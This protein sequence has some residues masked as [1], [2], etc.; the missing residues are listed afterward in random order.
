MAKTILICSNVYPPNFVGGAEL[1]AHYQAKVLKAKGR[2]V[3]VFAGENGTDGERYSM[4]QD[5]YDGLPVFRIF[6]QLRDYAAEFVNFSHPKVDSHF[7]CLLDAFSPDVVHMHNL[8][9][10]SLG[11]IHAAKRRGIKTVMT[12][13]DH[14]GVCFKNTLLKRERE[15]CTDYTRCAE[16][17]PTIEDGMRRN[18]PIQMRRDYMKLQLADVDAFIAPSAYLGETYVRAG[19]PVEKMNQIW[20]GIDVERFSRVVK[21]KSPERV[22]FTFIGFFGSHKGIDVLVDALALLERPERVLVN[23]VGGGGLVDQIRNRLETLRLTRSAK[24]WGMIDSS[25]I[26]EVFRETDV[27]ILPS[28]WPENQPVTITEAMATRTAV[29]A[30]AIG[31]IPELVIDGHNGYLFKPGSAIELAQKMN[32]FIDYPERIISFGNNGF[33]RIKE[34]SFEARLEQICS[35]YE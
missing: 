21:T 25:R 19:V 16:C 20:Y 13:H 3:I 4:R 11:V 18:L 30:S 26:E 7:N 35:L 27:L 1:I 22:R 8:I 14:W 2:N 28:V 5:E 31:G 6:L 15:I 12:L 23:L 34:N 24:L 10:L 33:E 32:E 9:G 29:I 17:M